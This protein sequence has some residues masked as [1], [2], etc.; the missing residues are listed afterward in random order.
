MR[1]GKVAHAENYLA[2]DFNAYPA[3]RGRKVPVWFRRNLDRDL[4][5]IQQAQERKVAEAR[6]SRISDCTH[7][8][9]VAF[10]I[11]ANIIARPKTN[12]PHR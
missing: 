1:K 5:S 11:G 3:R 12:E 4:L 7:H 6:V 10:N 2:I 8:R 9:A